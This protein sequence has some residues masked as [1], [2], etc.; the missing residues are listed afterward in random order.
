MIMDTTLRM[1]CLM[2][3]FTMLFHKLYNITY[4]VRRPTSHVTF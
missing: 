2:F 3:F 1:P 4:V